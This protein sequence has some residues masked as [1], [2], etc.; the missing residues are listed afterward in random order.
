M[1]GTETAVTTITEFAVTTLSHLVQ[2][3][4]AF[5]PVASLLFVKLFIF[6]QPQ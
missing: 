2:E 1:L 6:F 4:T 5:I 3:E